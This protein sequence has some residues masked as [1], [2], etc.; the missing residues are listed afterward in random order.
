MRTWP[1]PIGTIFIIIF[2]WHFAVIFF[3]IPEYLIPAPLAVGEYIFQKW[4]FLLRHSWV[5]T[6]E[7]LA[8][9]FLSILVGIPL[10]IA[11]VWSKILDRSIMP[12]LVVSQTFPKVAIAPLLIIW[13]GLGLLP[14]VL[15][16]FIIAFFPVVVSGVTGMRSVETEMLEL[17]HSMRASSLQVFWKM[18]LPYALPHLFSG[19][20]VA[21]TFAIVGAVI[22]EWVGADKGLGYML[23][24][25]NAN[26][27]T[28]LLFSILASLTVIGVILYYSVVMIERLIIPWHV[29]IREEEEAP[30]PTM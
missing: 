28:V 22:G 3:N 23:L 4:N 19:F 24:W 20:K 27:D 26:L 11:L 6:Y 17:I 5:T 7:T 21:I 14:K 29:S 2:L 16:S 9:F 10:A 18:R 30:Q 25:A 8:G 15:V 1:Y 13:F 12:I